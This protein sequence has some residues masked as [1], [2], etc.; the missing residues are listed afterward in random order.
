MLSMITSFT[1]CS[2]SETLIFCK[3]E[4]KPT[5]ETPLIMPDIENLNKNELSIHGH[6]MTIYLEVHNRIA[7]TMQILEKQVLYSFFFSL[8]QLHYSHQ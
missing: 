4:R 5:A 1:S 7:S 2:R 3:L 8:Y 6:F